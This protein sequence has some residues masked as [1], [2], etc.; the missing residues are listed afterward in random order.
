MSSAAR[1]VYEDAEVL[2]V[3]KPAGRAV[4]PGR[5]LPEEPLAAQLSRERGERL[6]VVHRLDRAASGLLV[7]A[8]SAAAHKRLS[9]AFE[10]RRAKKT[11][12]AVVSGRLEGRGRVD[13]ALKEFGS[14][15]MGAGPGGKP[16]LTEWRCLEAGA[17]ASFLEVAPVTGRRHQ[18]RVHLYA[19]GHPILGDPLYGAPLP[20]GGLPRLMLHAV[21]LELPG[22]PPLR[23]ETDAE[24][25][26]LT[27]SALRE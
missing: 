8:R 16:S 13:K 7:L 18:I 12:L 23:D 10:E 1:V 17:R 6:W 3:S 22:L 5:N 27:Q 19:L 9:A 4:I 15:R 24:F 20:V 2:A 21:A 26:R 14:G 11:Y 25:R